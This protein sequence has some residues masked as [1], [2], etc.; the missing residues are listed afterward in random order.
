MGNKWTY[1]TVW[2]EKHKRKK[3]GMREINVYD[4]V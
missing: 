1:G 4:I 2:I 3:T